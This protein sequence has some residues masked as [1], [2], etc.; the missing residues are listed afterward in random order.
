MLSTA[1]TATCNIGS[2]CETLLDVLQIAVVVFDAAGGLVFANEVARRMLEQEA[3]L[4]I[5]SG[6]LRGAPEDVTALLALAR[7]CAAA[8]QE[9][10]PP[11]CARLAREDRAP[12]IVSLSALRLEEDGDMQSLALGVIHDPEARISLHPGE[13]AERYGLTPAEGR[14]AA[15]IGDGKVPK[16]IAREL[17][18]GLTTV[19]THLKSIYAKLG[20]R[21]ANELIALL[22][23]FVFH[24]PLQG[25]VDGRGAAL[26][27]QRV[28]R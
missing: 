22:R 21:N 12:L 18:I 13:L 10:R 23:G 5:E 28:A 11:R 3:G 15:G 8:S 17:D 27:D 24:R 16:V 26:A 1:Q 19:R 14:I 9:D 2:L 20:V 25:A 4:R 6:R 7:E